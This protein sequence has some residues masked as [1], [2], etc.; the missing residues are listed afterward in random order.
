GVEREHAERAADLA[1]HVDQDDVLGPAE[2]DR[3]IATILADREREDVAGIASDVLG[4]RGR[5]GLGI[6]RHWVS[7]DER[8]PGGAS[9]YLFM[10][11]RGDGFAT[12]ALRSATTPPSGKRRLLAP[13][14]ETASPSAG[15]GT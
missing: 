13:P 5:K 15:G 11:R 2:R 10:Y 6:E 7:G 9:R 14:Q 4:S 3:E 1:R 12:L 8:C